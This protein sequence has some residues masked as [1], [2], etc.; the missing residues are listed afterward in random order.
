[1]ER[2]R[3]FLDRPM[4][5]RIKIMNPYSLRTKILQPLLVILVVGQALNS[6][7]ADAKPRRGPLPVLMV[8]ADQRDF[9]YR[10]YS[11]T[12][13]S[14][15]ASGLVVKVAATTTAKS[16]PSPNTGQPVGTDGAVVP[17]LR[18]ADV[19]ARN[20]SAIAFVG[21]WGSSMY[22]YAYND[23]NLD[24]VTDNYY[25]DGFYNGDDNL[26]D[27]KMGETKVIVNNLINQ[28]MARS[29]PVAGICHGVSVLAWARVDGASPLQG[30]K[31]ASSS[32]GSPAMVFLGRS[33]SDN[34]LSLH[35][36]VVMNGGFT[37]PYS[38]QY[39]DPT[40]VA[41]DV[42]VDGRIITAENYESASL[43]G[44]VIASEILGGN[45]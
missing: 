25:M 2:S 27:G 45:N 11:D 13:R 3:V 21:G 31:V 15:E 18:L 4:K 6:T 30:K 20:Y 29:K 12:R 42:I 7:A 38:G 17:D 33:Y 5:Q 34:E 1:M 36:Q 14:L 8:L 32:I 44:R 23:P 26:N 35:E 24:G 41:D 10:E 40:T 22:Q 39:G 16:I 19:D 28:F 9:Y 43:L 37:N